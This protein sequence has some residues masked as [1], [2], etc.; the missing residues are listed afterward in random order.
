[1]FLKCEMTGWH[2]QQIGLSAQNIRIIETI[3]CNMIILLKLHAVIIRAWKETGE[4]R[5]MH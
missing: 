2:T 4:G 1:M 5:H 3:H